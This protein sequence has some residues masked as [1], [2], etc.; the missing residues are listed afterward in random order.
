MGGS[1]QKPGPRARRAL[2]R[3]PETWIQ[4]SRL[5]EAFVNVLASFDASAGEG[6]SEKIMLKQQAKGTQRFNQNHPAL[7]QRLADLDAQRANALDLALNIVAGRRCGDAGGRAGHD[8][9][10]RG[11][12]NHFR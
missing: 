5:R 2:E 9:V 12:L 10:A 7:P 4:V 3:D 1:G 11:K 6:R 8:D